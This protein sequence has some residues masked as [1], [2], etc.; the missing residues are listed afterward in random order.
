MTLILI[1]FLDVNS[2]T[3]KIHRMKVSFF[4]PVEG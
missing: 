2:N 1:N 4:Q 3:D